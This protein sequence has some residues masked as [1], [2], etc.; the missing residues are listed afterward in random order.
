MLSF[1]DR[2]NKALLREAQSAVIWLNNPEIP[3]IRYEDLCSTDPE[4]RIA[5]TRVIADVSDCEFSL[6][7]S[8]IERAIGAP[9]ATKMDTPSRLEGYWT[10]KVEEV[11]LAM[12]FGDLNEQLGYTE[13]WC[14][15]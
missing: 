12:G 5:C 7:A 3:T 11:F 8:A 10:K 9:T 6:V 15:T 2:S 14:C 4:K 13:K 1:L